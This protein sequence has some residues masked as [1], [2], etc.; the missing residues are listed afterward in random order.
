MFRAAVVARAIVLSSAVSL[1]VAGTAQAQL[2]PGTDCWETQPGTTAAIGPFPDGFFGDVGGVPSDPFPKFPH[3]V[4]G[5]PLPGGTCTCSP[6]PVEFFD[7]HGNPVEP[8]DIHAVS[9]NEAIYDTCIDRPDP[10]PFAGGPGV[11]ETVPIEIIELSLKSVS[12][13]IVTY[14]GA[15]HTSCEL[16]IGLDGPQTLGSLEMTPFM[17]APPA[18]AMVLDAL[19]VKYAITFDCTGPGGPAASQVLNNLNTN[20]EGATGV[21]GEGS[22]VPTLREWGLFFAILGMM[23]VT[24]LWSYQQRQRSSE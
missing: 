4:E 21:F 20:F 17:V 19:P 2:P 15:N 18:G 1:L 10:V 8:D 12:P 23:S 14:G 3:P 9:S 7:M 6:D 11:P 13:I 24:E 16:F 5:V 22:P